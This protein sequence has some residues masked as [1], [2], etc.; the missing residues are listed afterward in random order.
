ML[1]YAIVEFQPENAKERKTVEVI[2]SSWLNE[3]EDECFWP[4]KM[5]IKFVQNLTPHKT[6]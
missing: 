5:P 2:A 1:P 6:D 4:P 3:E